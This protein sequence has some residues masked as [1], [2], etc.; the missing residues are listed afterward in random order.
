VPKSTKLGRPASPD[1]RRA[2]PAINSYAQ[3]RIEMWLRD[4]PDKL[5]THLAEDFGLSDYAISTL[6]N[7]GEGVGWGMARQLAKAFGLTLAELVAEADKYWEE[8]LSQQNGV[9]SLR[10]R[11]EWP[12]ALTEA[13]AKHGVS[14]AEAEAVGKWHAHITGKLTGATLAV[15]VGASK[16]MT[17]RIRPPRRR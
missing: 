10:D 1:G 16:G 8:Q 4:N 12:V 11:P 2:D 13:V 9:G 14:R 15:L 17:I 6:R 3:R 5:P 7:K